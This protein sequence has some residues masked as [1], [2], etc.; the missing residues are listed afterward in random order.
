MMVNRSGK[1][2]AEDVVPVSAC[3]ESERGY[4]ERLNLQPR[5][6]EDHSPL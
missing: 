5:W 3:F 4:I 2:Y 1:H 6:S